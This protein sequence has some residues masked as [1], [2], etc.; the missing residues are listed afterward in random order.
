MFEMIRYF[1]LPYEPGQA[2]SQPGIPI[3]LTPTKDVSD[4]VKVAR[5]T[6]AECYTQIIAD[7]VAARDLLPPVK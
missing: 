6:V 5:N 2:N 4:A 3:I 1:G 7:L